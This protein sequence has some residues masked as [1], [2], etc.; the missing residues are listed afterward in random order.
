MV[1]NVLDKGQKGDFGLVTGSA[2]CNTME[3]LAIRMPFDDVSR[4][5]SA[6]TKDEVC[7]IMTI[8]YYY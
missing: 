4:I 6:P 7:V 2:V 3:S 1:S 8:F 5:R